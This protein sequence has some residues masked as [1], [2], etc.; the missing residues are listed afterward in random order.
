MTVLHPWYFHE[1]S[2]A[3]R[4]N[5][6]ESYRS[7]WL[8]PSGDGR[9]LYF[10]KDVEAAGK[11]TKMK[12]EIRLNPLFYV[13]EIFDFFKCTHFLLRYVGNS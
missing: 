11:V 9:R 4:R 13:P 7:H 10:R 5:E 6:T 3:E 2:N 8:K 12:K 1:V